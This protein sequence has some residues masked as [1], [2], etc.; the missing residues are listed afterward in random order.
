MVMDLTK[1]AEARNSSRTA[2]RSGF[3]GVL[4]RVFSLDFGPGDEPAPET[5]ALSGPERD[6]ENL[7]RD[8]E[9]VGGYLWGAIRQAEREHPEIAGGRT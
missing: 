4:R 7:R 2:F 3:A 5:P 6:A 8:W 1:R 9:R